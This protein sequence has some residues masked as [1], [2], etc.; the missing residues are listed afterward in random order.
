[1]HSRNHLVIR[2]CLMEKPHVSKQ[3][4]LAPK[5]LLSLLFG[6]RGTCL[7]KTVT[8]GQVV[9]YLSKINGFAFPARNYC[10]WNFKNL[11]NIQNKNEKHCLKKH[12]TTCNG[13]V[14]LSACRNSQSPRSFRYVIWPLSAS[15]FL[16]KLSFAIFKAIVSWRFLSFRWGCNPLYSGHS[17][18]WI[19]WCK[20]IK[21]QNHLLPPFRALLITILIIRLF[22]KLRHW[23]SFIHSHAK[24]AL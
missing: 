18:V 10:L 14:Y 16:E 19:I 23:T 3:S 1:M 6:N 17:N 24:S 13:F 11:Q 21:R 12:E 8:D 7:N 15:H 2:P 4:T 5:S 22:F 20:G 9:V